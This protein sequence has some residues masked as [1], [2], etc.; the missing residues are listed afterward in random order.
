MQRRATNEGG[1]AVSW[2]RVR[3]DNV[4]ATDSLLRGRQGLVAAAVPRP[5]GDHSVIILLFGGF[6][7]DSGGGHHHH[8]PSPAIIAFDPLRNG[9]ESVAEETAEEGEAEL[10]CGPGRR[11][12]HTVCATNG[13]LYFFGGVSTSDETR[14]APHELDIFNTETNKWSREPM[15]GYP[16]SARKHHAA[17]VVGNQMYVFGG[18]DS[19]GTLCPPDMYILDLASKMCIM[20]FAEGPEPE[21]RMGHT[22]T[23]VG[24]K[25]YIIGGKGHD[26]RH[27][28]SIHILDTAALVWEKVEVG[29]TPLL[30]FH[31]AAAVD[32]HTIAVFGGEAPDGQPQPDLYLLNT[33]KLEWS[34]PRVS[35]VLPSGRS[36]HAWAM[37]NGRL[38]L[39]GGASTDSGGA[40]PL[41]D[42]FALTPHENE[43]EQGYNLV[44]GEQSLIYLSPTEE[45]EDEEEVVVD[46]AEEEVEVVVAGRERRSAANGNN[47]FQEEVEEEVVVKASTA[48]TTTTTERWR[49]RQ[50]IEGTMIEVRVI[51]TKAQEEEETVVSTSNRPKSPEVVRHSSNHHHHRDK[52]ASGERRRVSKKASDPEHRGGQH[53]KHQSGEERSPPRPTLS[54]SGSPPSDR[55]HAIIERLEENQR[56]FRSD[57]LIDIRS[58]ASAGRA[59]EIAAL[60]PPPQPV[61]KAGKKNDRAGEEKPHQ[62]G[63]R[64]SFGALVSRLSDLRPRTTRHTRAD[65][66]ASS[67]MHAV[68]DEGGSGS[69]GRNRSKSRSQ[70]V[71]RTSAATLD[72]FSSA[73]LGEASSSSMSSS[74]FSSSSPATPTKSDESREKSEEKKKRRARSKSQDMKSPAKK[75]KT[76]TPTT[77]KKAQRTKSSS[78]VSRAKRAKSEEKSEGSSRRETKSSG[79]K[80]ERKKGSSPTSLSNNNDNNSKKKVPSAP[81]P[82]ASSTSAPQLSKGQ[83]SP[84]D[85]MML[86]VRFLSD[87]SHSLSRSR[88]LIEPVSTLDSP[89]LDTEPPLLQGWLT[90]KDNKSGEWKMRWCRLLSCPAAIQFYKDETT[91]LG[92]IPLVGALLRVNRV[93]VKKGLRSDLAWSVASPGEPESTFVAKSAKQ[94]RKWVEAIRQVSEAAEEWN[95]DRAAAAQCLAVEIADIDRQMAELA[96][97]KARKAHHHRLLSDDDDGDQH[98]ANA[99]ADGEGEEDTSSSSTTTT[100]GSSSLD[101]FGFVTMTSQDIR[102]AL[103]AGRQQ[104]KREDEAQKSSESMEREET[105]RPSSKE[106]EEEEVVEGS[107]EWSEEWRRCMDMS[108][109]DLVRELIRYRRLAAQLAGGGHPPAS[110][111]QPPKGS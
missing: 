2:R 96:Q 35:G 51:N 47:N 57:L 3:T 54:S 52:K 73:Q 19:D 76:T 30:A 84:R 41:N 70:E 46:E 68:D 40:V 31:S 26:G 71:L 1:R 77:K 88:S 17:E 6:S 61:Q 97:L 63:R 75:N 59:A 28:E 12:H 13:L 108:V 15:Q 5:G 79:S 109:R 82:F 58:S 110:P 90:K 74:S 27:I 100:T 93:D 23:L 95:G 49:E 4:A 25:L 29:H 107:E 103:A 22:C 89:P 92:S 85:A 91:P 106:E 104:M 65:S 7:F 66:S 42:V 78:S 20:A 86:G 87:T 10:E 102:L 48:T 16:P 36:H 18:V 9:W 94:K 62:P 99:N 67:P 38:Y 56:Q 64:K 43:A 14:L 50:R 32:D 111:P 101:P 8:D 55:K 80:K 37:A 39:F 33:E 105:R 21:S 53:K 24:H 98:P 11:A 72:D 69:G 44:S 45:I 81:F 83:R 60:Q 34:V